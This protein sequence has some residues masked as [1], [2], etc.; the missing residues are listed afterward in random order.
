MRI[1]A[2]SCLAA[3]AALPLSAQDCPDL[4]PTLRQYYIQEWGQRYVDS[5]G[6]I[7]VPSDSNACEKLLYDARVYICRHRNNDPS[8]PILELEKSGIP[9][10]VAQAQRQKAHRVG[11]PA[12]KRRNVQRAW[13]HYQ[14]AKLKAGQKRAKQ[15]AAREGYQATVRKLKAAGCKPLTSMRPIVLD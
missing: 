2:L 1:H 11:G 7:P 13:G 4:K 15:I 8:S 14:K 9:V 12:A 10:I 6:G 5:G 3:L